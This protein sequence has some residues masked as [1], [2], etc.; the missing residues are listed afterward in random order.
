[1]ESEEFILECQNNDEASLDLFIKNNSNLVKSL[2]SRHFGGFG[3]LREDLEQ[4]GLLGALEAVRRYKEGFSK[5]FPTYK[6]LWIKKF[7]QNFIRKNKP[8]FALPESYDSVSNEVGA[9][10]LTDYHFLLDFLKKSPIKQGRNF[11]KQFKELL[12]R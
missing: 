8:L 3:S 10:F 6:S 9:E 4:E 7:M 5:Q 1:M 2:R 12:H 11:K